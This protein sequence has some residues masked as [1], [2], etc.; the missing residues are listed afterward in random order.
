MM[1][2][3]KKKLIMNLPYLLVFYVGNK[4]SW[5]FHVIRIKNL[6]EKILYA[7]NHMEVA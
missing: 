6:G 5:L 7:M 3:L 2:N 1:R 4:V